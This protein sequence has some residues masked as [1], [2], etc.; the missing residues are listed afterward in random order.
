MLTTYAKFIGTIVLVIA[1]VLMLY[2]L[3][4][5]KKY[6]T[7]SS[8]ASVPKFFEYFYNLFTENK[9][10]S[11]LINS[12]KR[13]LNLLSGSEAYS[14]IAVSGGCLLIPS[15][16]YVMMFIT[17]YLVSD[18]YYVF[19]LGACELFIPYLL[20]TNRIIKK[21][22]FI[23]HRFVKIYESSERY[24]ANKYSVENTF[25]EIRYNTT[26]TVGRILGEF[27]KIYSQDSS[28]AYEYLSNTIGDV[29]GDGFCKY[30]YAYDEEGVDPCTSI[31]KLALYADRDYSLKER[32]AATCKSLTTLCG[33][34][35]CI[36]LVTKILAERS[37]L[38]VGITAPFPIFTS[39][40]LFCVVLGFILILYFERG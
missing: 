5:M 4:T 13:N 14:K 37:A 16:Y 10:I 40:A 24:F 30:I 26:G 31:R 35:F 2:I 39:V 25:T 36:V 15:L 23:R 34:T 12:Y 19:L 7:M 3:V 27:L 11:S 38:S 1:I 6:K 20:I 33:V 18:W 17:V 32:M 8:T 21:S 22:N 29:W 9:I 28:K